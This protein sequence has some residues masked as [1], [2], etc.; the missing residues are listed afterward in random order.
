MMVVL[1]IG[2][3]AGR[4]SHP[5]KRLAFAAGALS[6]RF[7][8]IS[9]RISTLKTSSNFSGFPFVFVLYCAGSVLLIKRWYSLSESLQLYQI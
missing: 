9:W 2:A 6:L 1:R 3:G 7:F 5:L 4:G 8:I